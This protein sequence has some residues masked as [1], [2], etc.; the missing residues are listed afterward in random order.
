MTDPYLAL[1]I[2]ELVSDEEVAA[3]Y[4]RKLREFPPEEHPE[5]FAF[6]SEAYGAIRTEADRLD[7]RL[8][9]E[10]PRPERIDELAQYEQPEPPDPAR[11]KW[12]QVALEHWLT[13][14]IS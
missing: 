5:E 11:A 13:G 12:Q 6:I 1:G 10:V 3:A 4:H 14:R 8:F 2:H 9:G 7:L